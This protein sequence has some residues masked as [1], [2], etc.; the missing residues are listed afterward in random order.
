M[1]RNSAISSLRRALA[2]HDL[3][4]DEALAPTARARPWDAQRSAAAQ[5]R[6]QF[7]P[8]RTSPLNEQ[9]LVDGL[10]ADPHRH[11]VRKV[12]RQ[13]ARDLFRAPCPSPSSL[14]ST[15][16]PRHCRTGDDDAVR[17]DHQAR[18]A[19]LYLSAQG[20]IESELRWLR[21]ARRSLSV[22]LRR[23]RAIIQAAAARSCVAP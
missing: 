16:L 12:D 17:S 8:Q 15:S 6:G 9:R 13:P 22:P 7:A 3:G 1:A 2:N 18:Q 21:S 23:C 11:V 10:V 4:R 5:A 19:L 14:L 20:R